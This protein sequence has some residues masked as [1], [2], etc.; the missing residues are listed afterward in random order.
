MRDGASVSGGASGSQSTAGGAVAVTASRFV[1]SE[2]RTL[3]GGHAH[4][5]TEGSAAT[6]GSENKV[7]R[8]KQHKPLPPTPSMKNITLP[9]D[10]T[11]TSAVPEGVHHSSS[12]SSSGSNTSNR[13]LEPSTPQGSS[14]NSGRNNSNTVDFGIPGSSVAAASATS[15]SAVS[16]AVSAV[17]DGA[18]GTPGTPKENRKQSA[19]SSIF[20]RLL[21][22][23]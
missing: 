9:L 18:P 23:N 15:A 21:G 19:K 6:A 17:S 16:P 10:A 8:G 2:I 14:S 4:A 12:I 7:V 11:S 20:S 13:E 1:T 5:P 22:Q 3:R